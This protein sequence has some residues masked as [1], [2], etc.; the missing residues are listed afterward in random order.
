[1][2]L[3]VIGCRLRRGKRR[4]PVHWLDEPEPGTAVCGGFDGSSTFDWTCIKL[5]TRD[6]LL[7]TPRFGP[8]RRPAVWTPAEH[9]GVIP[10]D[11]VHAAWAEIWER[12]DVSRVYCDPWHWQ[13]E[14][15]TWADM[16]G[17]DVFRLWHTNRDRPM[18]AALTRFVTDLGTGKLTHDGCPLTAT[19]MGNAVMVPRSGD[20]FIIG[21]P[22]K[23]QHIDLAVTSVLAHEAAADAR[24]S[25]WSETV[26]S[27]MFVFR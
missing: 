26:D 1:M 17:E 24:V 21:K 9:G 23:A 12:F 19:H 11:Q 22:S 4:G 25:G 8:D 6:G 2:R 3:T 15:D 18:H 10:R 27:T 20:R 13:S 14:I 7:F 16:F 5:E